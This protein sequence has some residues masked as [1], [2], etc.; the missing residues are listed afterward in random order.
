MLKYILLLNI[1]FLGT[2]SFSQELDSIQFI[3]YSETKEYEIGGVSVTGAF[4]SDENAVKSVAGLQV[5]NKIR[6]PGPDIPKA[7]RSLWRLRLFTDVRIIQDKVIGEHIFLEIHLQ[8]RA[9]LTRFAHRGIKKSAHDGIN[10]VIKPFLV[11][12]QIVTEDV[13]LNAVRAI[14]KYYKGKGFLDVD[15]KVEEETDKQVKNGVQLDFN[16]NKNDRVKIANISFS[17]NENVKKKKLRNLLSNT[18]KKG[19]IFTKSKLV[20]NDYKEDK[21]N[22]INHY[23]TLGYRDMRIVSDSI[24]RDDNGLINL[25]MNID[26]G[27]RYYFRD[28]SWK[29]NSIH[30]SQRLS[31]ILGIKKGDVY[32]NELL[33]SRLHFSLDGRDISSLYLDDGYLFFRVDPIE[34]AVENDSIDLEMRIFEGPQATI[35]RVEIKGNERTHEHVIR[36]ELRTKPGQKFSRSD[37]VRSQRQILN[38]GYFNQ[39]NLGID[40]PVDPERGTVDIIYTVEERPSD[41]LELSAGWGGFGTSKVIGTLGVTFN[42]F[43]LRNIFNKSAWRPLPQGD[44]QK[45]SIRA[46]TNGNFYQSYNFTFTEPWLGGKKPNSFSLGAVYTAFD[47]EFFGGGKL[48]INRIF[49][50]I[51]T[52][53]KWPDD[54]FV[55]SSTVNIETINLDNYATRDFVT[56]EG[57]IVSNG[58]FNNFYLQTTLARTSINEPIFPRS[59]SKISLSVQLTPPWTALGREVE[60]FSDPEERYRM[61][62]YHKWRFDTEWYATLVGKLVFKA[63]VKMGL[64]GYYNE[65]IGIP[66]FEKFELGGDGLSNQQFGITGKDIISLRGYETEN[67]PANTLGGASIFDKFTVELRYPLSLNPSSTIFVL[68]FLEGGNSW[69]GFRNFNPFDMK[70]SA[71]LGLRVFLPMFGLLGF[72]YGFGFDKPLLLNRNAPWKEYG[73]FSIILGFEPE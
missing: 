2:W 10:D 40:T 5:G 52:R 58:S 69:N 8:E 14:E 38:L 45:L 49:T 62:E 42:N 15:V 37:I 67:L 64:L 68:G 9:R 48:S 39:E 66:P 65:D 56:P 57:Q 63:S 33:D 23:N 54:N 36:R 22:M 72:D 70:R 20:T 13:K 3:E 60:D 44:G 46:Q 27:N 61:V 4:F 71:G 26:E 29:G 17:G 55:L 32:N 18:K 6:V 31:A 59:G 1:L 41:Q 30:E 21:L 34:I 28:I 53:L 43:S 7:V 50:G 51:G 16:I 11:K 25:H 12:G 19:K 73:K 47:N 35:D 24:W